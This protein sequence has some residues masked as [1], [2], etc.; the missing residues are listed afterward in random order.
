V[1]KRHTGSSASDGPENQTG[2]APAEAQ[3]EGGQDAGKSAEDDAKDAIRRAEEE[4]ERAR[5]WY[6]EVRRQ[7]TERIK[8]VR[9]SGLGDITR[10]TIKLVRK[11]PGPSVIVAMVLGFF[12]GRLFRR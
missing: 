1:A 2:K 5:K 8:E 10:G 7:A 11:Y 12:L 3:G 4:L 6:K 9:E